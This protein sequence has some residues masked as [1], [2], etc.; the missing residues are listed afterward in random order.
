MA[1]NSS[2]PLTKDDFLRELQHYATKEDLANL[3]ADLFKW[4]AGLL[5]SLVLIG[6]A[7][8]ASL[9]IQL[10]LLL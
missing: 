10:I 5:A 1:S 7:A 2:A 4:M 9:V 3:K 6:I 8:A